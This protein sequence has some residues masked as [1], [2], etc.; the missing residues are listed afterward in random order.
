M[1]IVLEEMFVFLTVVFWLYKLLDREGAAGSVV[2]LGD[3]S[4]IGQLLKVLGTKI[5]ESTIGTILHY[6]LFSC[7]KMWEI[8]VQALLLTVPFSFLPSDGLSSSEQPL[9]RR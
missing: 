7:G 1:F 5:L 9:R 2:S 4:P 3:F 6:K 8:L